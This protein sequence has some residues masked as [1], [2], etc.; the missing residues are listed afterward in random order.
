MSRFVIHYRL[1]NVLQTRG[2]VVTDHELER[3][4]LIDVRDERAVVFSCHEV[5]VAQTRVYLQGGNTLI[6]HPLWSAEPA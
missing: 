6:P 5:N 1:D 4:D 2:K 3:G